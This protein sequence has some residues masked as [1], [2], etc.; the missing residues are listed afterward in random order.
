MM[1]R[2]LQSLMLLG[3]VVL[4]SSF[5]FGGRW[6]PAAIGVGIF[7]S[8]FPPV[9]RHVDRWLVGTSKGEDADQA[10]VLRM[11]AGVAIAVLAII[12]APF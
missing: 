1:T 7:A 5:F 8:A 4:L 11:A 6:G 9:R 2:A 3:G 10:A 12:L